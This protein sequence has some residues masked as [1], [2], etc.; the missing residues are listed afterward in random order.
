MASVELSFSWVRRLNSILLD[1]LRMV[2]QNINYPV[3]PLTV[4]QLVLVQRFM[5]F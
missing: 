3:W 4:N 1:W 5:M 2:H